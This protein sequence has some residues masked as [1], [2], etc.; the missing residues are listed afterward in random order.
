MDP[1]AFDCAICLQQGKYV[2][3]LFHSIP[4]KKQWKW[5]TLCGD[6]GQNWNKWPTCSNDE[7]AAYSVGWNTSVSTI[8]VFDKT[9]KV[10]RAQWGYE[11]VCVCVG[12]WSHMVP[13][14]LGKTFCTAIKMCTW[15]INHNVPVLPEKS[16]YENL[17][18]FMHQQQCSWS[19]LWFPGL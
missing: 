9:I 19:H 14:I 3:K 7:V 6:E 1:G 15:E 4:C 10:S 17:F 12:G 2:R 16:L 5:N 11:C 13:E 8:K 18:I